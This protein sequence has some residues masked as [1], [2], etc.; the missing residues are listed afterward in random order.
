MARERPRRRRRR[1]RRAHD[2]LPH[3]SYRPPNEIFDKLLISFGSFLSSVLLY[4]D[5]A[6]CGS[7]IYAFACDRDRLFI[8]ANRSGAP[9]GGSRGG[10]GREVGPLFVVNFL[11]CREKGK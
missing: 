2:A 3:T 9:R 8:A 5:A 10:R 11:I 4:R 6:K 1:R 7:G